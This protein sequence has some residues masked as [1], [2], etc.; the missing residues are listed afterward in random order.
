MDGELRDA[1][2]AEL[3]IGEVARTLQL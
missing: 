3:T 1:A 2:Y